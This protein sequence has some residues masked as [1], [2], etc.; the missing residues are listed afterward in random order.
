MNRA[1]AANDTAPAAGPAP[2]RVP[3]DWAAALLQQRQTILPRRLHA[4]G[5]TEAELAQ[6]V[7]AAASAPDHGQL[8][9]WRFVLVP[10]AARAALAD[11]FEQS[12]AERDPQATSAQRGQAREKAHRAPTLLL[13]VARLADDAGGHGEVPVAER[14]LSA[15]CALQNML[16]MATALGYGS[17]L[18]SGKALQSPALRRLFGLGPHEQALCFLSIGTPASRRPPKARPAPAAYCSVLELP[19]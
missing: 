1:D 4:P 3:A 19:R 17:A 8:L 2:E 15:G 5:P 12:L 18:T 16:L 6:I 9:P 13:A 11:A 10:A 14:L 7:A